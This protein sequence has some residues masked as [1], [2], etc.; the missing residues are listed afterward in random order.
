MTDALLRGYTVGQW[1]KEAIDEL[2]LSDKQKTLLETLN[3]YMKHK[4]E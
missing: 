2:K 3:H 1:P 4:E